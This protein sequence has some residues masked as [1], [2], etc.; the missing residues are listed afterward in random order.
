MSKYL[1]KS[2]HPQRLQAFDTLWLRCTPRVGAQVLV[3]TCWALSYLSDGDTDRITAVM[4]SGVVA[5]LVGLL[6]HD[7]SN[8]VTPALRTLGNFVTGDDVQTQVGLFFVAGI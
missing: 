1:D 5:P 4:S 3:D 2:R 8:V 7:D 6:Q